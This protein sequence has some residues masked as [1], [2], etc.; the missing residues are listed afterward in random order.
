MAA[1]LLTLKV[2]LIFLMPIPNAENAIIAI[3]KLRDYCLNPE[4]DEGKRKAL[5]FSTAFSMTANDAENLRQILLEVVK[6]HA[7]K[8]G[9]QDESRQLCTSDFRLNGKIE[10]E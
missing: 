6:T 3:R 1:T 9:G 2:K 8:L 10:V 5:L 4:R 7:A